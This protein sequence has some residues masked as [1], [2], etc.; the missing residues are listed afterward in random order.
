MEYVLVRFQ[1]AI[2]LTSRPQMET[3]GK[4]I[5]RYG[6]D[7]RDGRFT[8][9]VVLDEQTGF[10][11]KELCVFLSATLLDRRKY[12]PM[13]PE[14]M[15][16]YLSLDD[17]AKETF[18]REHFSDKRSRFPFVDIFLVLAIVAVLVYVLS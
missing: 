18:A 15:E 12:L 11:D 13:N 3:L 7:K 16:A 4:T 9:L 2:Y 5:A 17:I 8:Q 10:I 14:L 1:S 6:K